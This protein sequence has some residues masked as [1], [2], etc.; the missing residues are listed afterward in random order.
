ML[1][2]G[3]KEFRNL[4]EQVFKNMSDIA[5]I[6]ASGMVL[7][8]FGIKVVGQESSVANMPTVADYKENNPDWEYGDAY[9]IGTEAPYELYVLTREDANHIDDYWFNI[10]EFPAVGPQ[11]EQGPEGP[12]GPQG[13]TGNP[14]QNGAS[15]GFGTPTATV[16][17]LEPEEDATVSISASGPDT[18][19]VFSFT[20]GIPKGEAGETPTLEWGNISGDIDDQSDLVSALQSKQ[21]TLVSG[22][23]IKTINGESVLGSGNLIAG[24]KMI[25]YG[26]T[27]IS[28][29][30]LL[31]FV[32]A[33]GTVVVVN[34]AEG[35]AEYYYLATVARNSA[36]TQ[37][38]MTF[39]SE[40]VSSL[41]NNVP[42]TYQ[43]GFEYS[44]GSVTWSD[45]TSA[46]GA[47]NYDLVYGDNVNITNLKEAI[48]KGQTVRVSKTTTD[49]YDSEITSIYVL[50]T[51]EDAE[52]YYQLFFNYT[53]S[54]SANSGTISNTR[55]RM[56]YIYSPASTA[57]YTFSTV[58]VDNAGG[59]GGT[60]TDVEVNGT[61]VV[62]GGVA[63]ITISAAGISGDYDDLTNKPTIPS[64]TSDLINDSDFITSSVDDLTY[65]TKTSSLAAVAISGSYSDLSNKPSIPSKTSDLTNDSGFIDKSVNDLTYYTL[66]SALASVATSGSYND[67]SNKPSIPAA[68]VNSDWEASSGVAEILHK[69]DLSVYAESSSLGDCA[70]LD[71]NELSIAY[72]QITGTPTIPTAT[73]D[74]TND[75]GFITSSVNNLTNY[76]DKT[77]V[78]EIVD[79]VAEDI[80]TNTSDLI[81]DSGFITSS[82]LS[83][84]VTTSTDQ[85]ISSTK[86]IAYGEQI[87]F[88]DSGDDDAYFI[89][90]NNADLKVQSE[91]GLIL[92]SNGSITIGSVG[93][94]TLFSPNQSG[95]GLIVPSTSSYSANKTIATLDDIP[96]SSDFVTLS[97]D[98]NNIT[99]AKTFVNQNGISIAQT[100]GGLNTDDAVVNFYTYSGGLRLEGRVGF[101]HSDDF[102][103]LYGRKG[104][105]DGATGLVALTHHEDLNS[106]GTSSRQYSA[107][108][109]MVADKISYL[110]SGNVMIPLAVSFNSTHYTANAGGDVILPSETWTFTLS[111]GTTTTKTI[112]VG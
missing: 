111:D 58:S 11:G 72:S 100:S 22:T 29:S 16:T 33:G 87:R 95:Y 19:K 63:D 110:G 6:K 101:N 68:Q 50:N 43:C 39:T 103:E 27:T 57:W 93:I 71:E 69:P 14:G 52:T 88:N 28:A 56:T 35:I 76:Y 94:N 83:G 109:P 77:D 7:D 1:K 41:G 45:I 48:S 98:Q 102:V 10:G 61:S 44:S 18:E 105:N 5:N 25:N 67:L 4:Q 84:Y 74:L 64:K 53:T 24:A 92:S 23:S 81:N 107:C 36:K 54:S 60:I 17:T 3:N 99:G 55:V 12:Q 51:I 31:A 47:G 34:D 89:G 66:S 49:Q 42:F 46:R 91:N 79:N 21:N 104:Y 108:L 82:D 32:E 8:E 15:A 97:T 65:Y 78:D 30:D 2:F 13:E 38:S 86:T 40:A 20:F 80:P 85:T 9:A 73:S 112:V 90:M 26:D 75:S 62:S 37:I 59:G 106:A 96:S 70:Y